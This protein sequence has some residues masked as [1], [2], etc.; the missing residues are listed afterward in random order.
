MKKVYYYCKR[1]YYRLLINCRHAIGYRAKG[2]PRGL[3]DVSLT[4]LRIWRRV[5]HWSTSDLLYNPVTSECYAEVVI[6]GH[7][8]YCFLE[9]GRLRIINT[10]VGYDVE[11]S[12]EA[13]RWCSGVFTREV[14][15]RRTAFKNVALGRVVHSL[16]DLEQRLI[17]G[18]EIESKKRAGGKRGNTRRPVVE[19]I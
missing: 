18:C 14:N 15:R 13:E 19:Q 5:V 17:V 7:R 12:I 1:L 8:V 4:A 3:S 11:L 10:V 6:G 16:D 2:V 9:S